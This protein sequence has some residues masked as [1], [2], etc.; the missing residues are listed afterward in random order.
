MS[1]HTLRVGLTQWHPTLDLYANTELALEAI[2]RCAKEQP[3]LILLPENGLC[4]GSGAQMRERALTLDA[5][6]IRAI[7]TAARNAHAAVVLG[8][9]KR[10]TEN[11]EV[12]NSALVIGPDGEDAGIY[13][14]IHLF[15]ARV[16]GRTFNAS[17]VEQAGA[18]PLIAEIAGVRVGVTI[19]FDVRFPDLARHLALAGAE[20][21][22]VPAAFTETTGRAH[23]ET[24]LRARAIENS[25][26][27]VASATIS[28]EDE[29][30]AT[31][32]HAMVVEPFGGVLADLQREEFACAIVELDLTARRRIRDQ[33]PVLDATRP[34]ATSAPPH[35]VTVS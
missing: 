16:D 13:D 10:L 32:G 19:C 15:N 29:P 9:F 28:G 17:A 31:Y 33:I 24:L 3:D 20:V 6:P 34:D 35:F 30:M 5:A 12:Y 1:A 11:G 25:V 22:L 21:L 7:A 8:G 2:R 18:R 27:V 23:W 14:K 4:L 26:Y